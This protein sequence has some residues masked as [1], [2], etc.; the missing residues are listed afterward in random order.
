MEPWL[1]KD[2]LQ[3]TSAAGPKDLYRNSTVLKCQN[4]L[5]TVFFPPGMI[6]STPELRHAASSARSSPVESQSVITSPVNPHSSLRMSVQ[7]SLLSAQYVPFSL[8]YAD[9]TAFGAAYFTAISYRDSGGISQNDN[10]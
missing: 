10:E 7:S 5:F 3:D 6:R 4:Q 8:L 1:F 2:L 9:I